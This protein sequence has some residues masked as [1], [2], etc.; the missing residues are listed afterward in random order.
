MSFT[1]D[2]LIRVME[3]AKELGVKDF[4]SNEYQVSFNPAEYLS[5]EETKVPEISS[6]PQFTDE[7][8]AKPLQ[9]FDEILSDPELVLFAATPHFDELLAEKQAKQQLK[10]Q[11]MK[12]REDV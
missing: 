2:E 10:E 1:A 7:E 5:S 9:Y 8:L 3:K 4:K 12:E 6:P 11:S